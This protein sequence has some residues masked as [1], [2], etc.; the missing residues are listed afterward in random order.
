MPRSTIPMTMT[1]ESSQI[2]G[3]GYDAASQTMVLAFQSSAGQK[4]YEYPDTPPAK[5]AELD[6][7]ESKGRWWRAN[8][9]NFPNF[10]VMRD[11]PAPVDTEGG[12]AD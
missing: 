12:A 8:R 1:P 5:F 4:E 9:A 11:D 10:R 7:A 2:A 3:Y 6:A